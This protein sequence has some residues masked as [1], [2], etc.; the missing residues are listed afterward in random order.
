MQQNVKR[1][2]ALSASPHNANDQSIQQQL[3]L[4]QARATLL[5]DALDDAKE[6]LIRAG[7]DPQAEIK[8]ELEEHEVLQHG[9]SGPAANA[10][11]KPAAF[12]VAGN[13]VS[14]FQ[15][16]RRLRN[17]YARLLAAQQQAETYAATLTRKH[18]ALE[19]G[20][21]DVLGDDDTSE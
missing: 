21:S 11:S 6:D 19:K 7:G 1:L 10:S 3:E 20:M 8:Q 2:T 16:W 15:T 9:T 5:Q 18:Q 14:Q 13:L 17:D 4:A 12:G